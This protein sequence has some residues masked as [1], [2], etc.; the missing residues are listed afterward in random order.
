MITDNTNVWNSP[1]RNIKGQV[2]LSNSS[3]VST[4]G[5]RI[6]NLRNVYPKAHNITCKIRNTNLIPFPYAN[7]T[8]T[9]NG[10][11]YTVNEDRSV[12]ANGTATA[13]AFFYLSNDI[14]LP[15]GTYI[16]NSPNITTELRATLNNLDGTLDKYL[17]AGTAFTTTENKKLIYQYILI[18]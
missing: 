10:V 11:T 17:Q 12:T 6:I 4:S 15:P 14:L 5:K 16:F 13:D 7:T 1:V 9:I 18:Y 8:A 3:T 2:E